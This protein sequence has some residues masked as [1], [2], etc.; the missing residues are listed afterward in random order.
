MAQ[1]VAV[2]FLTKHTL[3]LGIRVSPFLSRSRQY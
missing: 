1:G 3:L 2:G